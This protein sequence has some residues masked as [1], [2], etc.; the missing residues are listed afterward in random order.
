[1]RDNIVAGIGMLMVSNDNAHVFDLYASRTDYVASGSTLALETYNPATAEKVSVVPILQPVSVR[2]F[3]FA[4]PRPRGAA[5]TMRTC[6]S[7]S[8][9]SAHAREPWGTPIGT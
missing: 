2:V 1:M 6:R 5:S 8:Q 7:M 4:F 9:I 3:L